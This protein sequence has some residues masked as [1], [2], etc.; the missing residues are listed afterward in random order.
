MNSYH[1]Y[2]DAELLHLLGQDDQEAFTELYERFWK[3]LFGIAYNRLQEITAA[4][5]VVHDVFAALWAGRHRIKIEQLENY[6]ATA[7]KYAVL[8]QVR[9]ITQQRKYLGSQQQVSL[10]EIPVESSLHFKK[11]LEIIKTEVEK[12]PDSCRL[13][14]KCSREQGKPIKQIASELNISHKTVENQLNKAL[15]HLKLATRH[16]LHVV[17]LFL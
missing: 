2:Q 7:T 1:Q 14:F 5:D 4:E 15:K 3:K 8:S 9:K 12:L 6:L 11:I 13:I 16:F 10:Y 17:I